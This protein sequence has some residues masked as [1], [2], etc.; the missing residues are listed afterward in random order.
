MIF[1]ILLIDK[2]T[3]DKEPIDLPW[4]LTDFRRVAYNEEYPEQVPPNIW[5]NY[6]DH[7]WSLDNLPFLERNTKLQLYR[8]LK[9]KNNYN[10]F[11]ERAR[12]LRYSYIKKLRKN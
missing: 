7:V 4:L 6:Y 8:P 10:Y 5:A 3:P 1:F 2:F 12:A 9:M 11:S